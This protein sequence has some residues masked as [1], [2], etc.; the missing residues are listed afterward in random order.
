MSGLINGVPADEYG[1]WCRHG[2]RIMVA[3]PASRSEYPPLVFA[4]PWPCDEA[5]CTRE[6][7]ERENA[8][9]AAEYEA[10]RW[11]EYRAWVSS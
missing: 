10:D 1:M 2:E 4:E 5:A 7:V 3:D 8:E 9:L 11:A 6:Q